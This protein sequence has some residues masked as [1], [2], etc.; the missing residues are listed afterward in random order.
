MEFY[1]YSN[2]TK[3]NGKLQNLNLLTE[4]KLYIKK[5]VTSKIN[6]NKLK[7]QYYNTNNY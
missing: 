2:V 7:K 3:N 1:F 5:T 6:G 4:Q